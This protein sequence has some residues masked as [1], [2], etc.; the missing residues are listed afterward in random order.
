M[1]PLTGCLADQNPALIVE[2]DHA[3]CQELTQ[4]IGH[5]L[6]RLSP[7]DGDEAVGGP[8]VNPYDHHASS[9]CGL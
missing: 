2:T 4:G 9:L 3:G 6:A 8:Q 7:P 5:Q 1:Q